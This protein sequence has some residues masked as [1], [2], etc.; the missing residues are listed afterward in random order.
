MKVIVVQCLLCA[1]VLI[2]IQGSLALT[3]ICPQILEY[4]TT[5]NSATQ[6]MSWSAVVHIPSVHTYNSEPNLDI[7][8]DRSITHLSASNSDVM[9]SDWRKFNILRRSQTYNRIHMTVE[10]NSESVPMVEEIRLNGVKICPETTTITRNPNR[11]YNAN[12]QPTQRTPEDQFGATSTRRVTT[13]ERINYLATND[14]SVNNN[15]NNSP[16]LRTPAPQTPS[17]APN[18]GNDRAVHDVW[19]L[20]TNRDSTTT[21]RTTQ[22]TRSSSR[23][24]TTTTTSSPYF[25]G[26]LHMLFQSNGNDRVNLRFIIINC[27]LFMLDVDR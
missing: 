20:N 8:L 23:P 9:T 5:T 15:G 19:N 26:D 1:L 17:R 18:D 13:T 14:D 10:F 11:D 7:I 24:V 6:F 12:R 27:N 16:P 2:H 22:V 3:S 25:P 4:K 21:R